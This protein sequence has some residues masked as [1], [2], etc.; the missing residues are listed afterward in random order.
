MVRSELS[1]PSWYVLQACT[2]VYPVTKLVRN[3]SLQQLSKPRRRLEYETDSNDVFYVRIDKN[4]KLPVTTF[5]RA[6]GLS[7]DAQILE[8]FGEDARIQATIEKDSTNNTEEA[9]LEVYRNAI[10]VNHQQ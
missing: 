5:I 1:F 7:S 4:R 9:L 2:T 10:Q 6:L 8:F 3:F